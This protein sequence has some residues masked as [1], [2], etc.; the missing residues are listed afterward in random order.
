MFGNLITFAAAV[1]VIVDADAIDPSEVGL[2]I[3]YAL[4]VTQ[5]LNW[6][7]RM[8][9]DVETNIVAVER[10]KEYS[11]MGNEANWTSSNSPPTD[12]PSSGSV[13]FSDYGKVHFEYCQQKF[14]DLFQICVCYNSN[15]ELEI[16]SQLEFFIL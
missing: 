1:F 5:I 14:K 7:V 11:E 4:S 15:H 9:A 10:I 8:T 6:L 2:I 12:W 13:T 16:I 3:T